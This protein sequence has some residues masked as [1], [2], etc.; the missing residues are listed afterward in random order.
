MVTQT[1]CQHCTVPVDS[2]NICAFCATYTPLATLSQRLDEIMKG[3]DRL[4]YLG[5]DVLRGLPTDAPLFAVADLVTA[6]GHL[7]QAAVSF[8]RAIDQFISEE[9][10]R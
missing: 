9:M 3:I 8:D 7:R 5:N 6:L 4:R 1:Q 10:A 2:G